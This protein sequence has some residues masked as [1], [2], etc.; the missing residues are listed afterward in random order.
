[1]N[2]TYRPIDSWPGEL[3]ARRTPSPFQVGE[4][5]S[6]KLLAYE[7]GKLG[8]KEIVLQLAVSGMDLR[9]DGRPK[10]RADYKHPGVIVSFDS[11]HGPL[12]YS[13]DVFDPRAYPA[14]LQ[15]PRRLTDM[16]FWQMHIPFAFALVEMTRPDVLVE[17]GTHKGDSYAAFCQAVQAL[18]LPTKCYAVDTWGGDIH[19][20]SYD[21]SVYRNLRDHHN[22]LYGGFS[23]LVRRRLFNDALELIEDGSI[24][25]L[26][27]DGAHTYEAV[28]HD[29]ET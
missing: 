20:R 2:V 23:C 29:F 4:S 14:A 27:I 28:R 25:V 17:L 13:T 22:P 21:D 12:K 11:K 26:H 10:L 24:D 7:V 18:D 8:G 5:E 1:M 6:R 15:T 3:T 19:T 16:R 9:V